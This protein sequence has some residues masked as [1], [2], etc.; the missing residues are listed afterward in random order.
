M[1]YYYHIT[2]G[3]NGLKWVKFGSG[4]NGRQAQVERSIAAVGGQ[5]IASDRVSTG[6]FGHRALEAHTH[7][8]HALTRY[9]GFRGLFDG[10]T[11]VWPA[12]EASALLRTA[13]RTL[14][15]MKTGAQFAEPSAT[16]SVVDLFRSIILAMPNHKQLSIL[17]LCS[18]DGVLSNNLVG[19]VNRVAQVTIDPPATLP[20]DV[21]NFDV[22]VIPGD[23]L[24]IPDGRR[25]DVVVM[26][27]PFSNRKETGS[28]QSNNY[29]WHFI[30]KAQALAPVVVFIAPQTWESGL[31][32]EDQTGTYEVIEYAADF[33]PHPTASVVR[34]TAGPEFR[35]I[36]GRDDRKPEMP[37][38]DVEVLPSDMTKRTA[39]SYGVTEFGSLIEPGAEASPRATLL[40]G[41]DAEACARWVVANRAALV[42]WWGAPANGHGKVRISAIREL[43]A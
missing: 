2:F 29:F 33:G 7:K 9:W 8:Q 37:K 28:G 6:D 14:A 11:E 10:S 12:S 40:Q 1:N 21:P 26:N 15:A 41:V 38:F 23:A 19:E 35:I 32:K 42:A 20:G 3:L 17:D 31:A 22:Q 36:G 4:T 5:I 43:L 13:A 25:A 34:W 30:R 39:P 27:P 16:A 18:G 24:A